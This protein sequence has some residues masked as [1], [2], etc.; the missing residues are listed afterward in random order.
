MA[1][2]SG[3]P[4]NQ[5]FPDLVDPVRDFV[6]K[7][8]HRVRTPERVHQL[9][10][11]AAQLAQ[12]ALLDHREKNPSKRQ[13][14]CRAGCSYC[15]SLQVHVTAPE[16]LRIADHLRATYSQEALDAVLTRVKQADDKTRGLDSV[17]RFYARISCPFL[18][19]NACSIY[20][21]RP[22][23]CRGYT[24]YSWLACLRSRQKG[25]Q[26]RPIPRGAAQIDIYHS[27]LEGILAGLDTVGLRPQMLELIAAVRV[28][29][30][31]PNSTEAWLKG[32]P[33]FDAAI[34][35]Y[36]ENPRMTLG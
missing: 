1:S 28:A 11:N 36:H 27:A 33:V 22:L 3:G 4:A 34:L 16:I 14:S 13:V 6:K 30:E 7:L 23:A 10:E 21:V 26:K 19:D 12:A 35:P 31:R 8:L 32:E 29:L 9:I 5:N 2:Q 15:C 25:L 24:S 18:I 20:N 17:Q